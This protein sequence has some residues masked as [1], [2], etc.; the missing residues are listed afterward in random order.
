MNKG[1]ALAAFGAAALMATAS[2]PAQADDVM[3]T[4][5]NPWQECGIGAVI[6]PDHGIAA[7]ISNIIWDLG[8]TAVTSA[9]VSKETCEG[10]DVIA[11]KFIDENYD[12][13]ESE[14]AIGEG[15]H[16]NAMLTMLGCEAA[17][18]DAVINKLRSELVVDS[19]KS[20]SE[21]AEALYFS[22]QNAVAQ[23]KLG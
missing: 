6:F 8:T 9:T 18:Q 1:I 23:C 14:L 3:G 2:Q 21:K 11:A 16:V 4:S 5:V 13:V 19:E 7:A 15:R 10:S 12:K 22:A 17:Q 20:N